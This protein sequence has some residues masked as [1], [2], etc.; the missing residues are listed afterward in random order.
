MVSEGMSGG[1][2]A[3]VDLTQASTPSEERAAVRFGPGDVLLVE[4]APG[5]AVV[6]FSAIAD[7]PLAFSYRWRYR[8]PGAAEQS[9]RGEVREQYV[10]IPSPTSHN[11]HAR[12]VEPLLG[13]QPRVSIGP[14]N[15]EWSSGGDYRGYFYFYPSR[16]K[17][18]L[19]SVDEF[20]REL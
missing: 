2:M 14:I 5:R 18:W 8:A 12:T 6:Q 10:A 17:V 4:V 11:G 15:T 1:P 13:H 9:G 19:R 7:Q 20:E 16:A 3:I